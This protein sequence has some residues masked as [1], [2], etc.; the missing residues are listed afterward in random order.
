MYMNK[1]L[2]NVTEWNH[3]VPNKKM[4]DPQRLAGHRGDLRP[5]WCRQTQTGD[6][7]ARNPR[8]GQW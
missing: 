5:Q 3:S 8:R 2:R 4:V 6:H 1:A 7:S